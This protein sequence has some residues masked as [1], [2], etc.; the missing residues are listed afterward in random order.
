MEN[1]SERGVLGSSGARNS[2]LKI[3]WNADHC[4][5]CRSDEKISERSNPKIGRGAERRK[6]PDGLHPPSPRAIRKG[7]TA[8]STK[9]FVPSFDFPSFRSFVL[10]HSF[11]FHFHFNLILYCLFI[12]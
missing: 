2:N 5:R 12:A 7:F 6:P 11:H 10:C 3:G 1:W 8:E 9:K 4:Y